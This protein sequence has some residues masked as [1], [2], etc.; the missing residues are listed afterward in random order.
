MLKKKKKKK[1]K[2]KTCSRPW[3]D[4]NLECRRKAKLM[5]GMA[6]DGRF[7]GDTS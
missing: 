2:K 3:A 4:H 1:K 6:V 7:S 5:G